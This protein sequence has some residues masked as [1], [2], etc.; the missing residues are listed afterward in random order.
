MQSPFATGSPPP[1]MPPA[2]SLQLSLLQLLSCCGAACCLFWCAALHLKRI[3]P[4]HTGRCAVDA[5]LAVY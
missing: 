4:Y 3:G 1:S 5:L 2:S